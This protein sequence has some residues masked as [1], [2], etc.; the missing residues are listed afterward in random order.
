MPTSDVG[1]AY[2]YQ[3]KALTE[4]YDRSSLPFAVQ[5]Q[6]APAVR[7]LERFSAYVNPNSAYGSAYGPQGSGSG[8]AKAPSTVDPNI[9][10]TAWRNLPKLCSFWLNGTCNRVIKKSCPFRPCCGAY[11]FPEIAGTDKEIHKRLQAQ[12]T[13]H[14][15]AYV[16]KHMEKDVKDCLR[17]GLKT[18]NKDEAIRKRVN[19]EDDLSKKYL[20]KIQAHVSYLCFIIRLRLL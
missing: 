16:M 8:S 13:E 2:Y 7:Q 3:S 5:L 17:N 15:P 1:T 10:R 14:G 9:N 18:G 12:L 6:E 11:V 4:G 20:G 19:G